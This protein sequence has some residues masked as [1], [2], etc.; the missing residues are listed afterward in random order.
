MVTINLVDVACSVD[1]LEQFWEL[2]NERLELCHKA[3]QCRHKRL[4]GTVSDVSP[5]HFQYGAIARLEKGEVIDDLLFNNYSTLSLGYAGLWECVYK[6]IGKKLTEEDGKQLGK[7]IMQYM[8]DKCA[9][10]REAENIGYSLYGSPIE[11]TAY[12]FAT[13]LQKRFGVIEGV[14]DR[15][16]ITNSYHIHVTE[17][18][19]IFNKLRIEAEFQPLSPGGQISY[20]EIPN[21]TGNTE[22]IEEVIKF[23]Y[24]NI[25]YAELNTKSDYCQECGW[26]GEIEIVED[27]TGKLIWKCP[28]CGNTNQDKMN[29]CRRTCGYLGS[30]F[31]N[32]GR[33]QEI[34][35]R[36][37]HL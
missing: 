32:Q 26:D 36:V 28:N 6:L 23:M 13:C 25:M 12:R 22:A 8:N 17:P 15:N 35:E 31:W 3:L 7:E 21:L 9:A 33:T 20:G 2:F 11:S 29:V 27:E 30:N 1:S 5:L 14:T 19:D 34:K 4:R 18:I 24:D 10:W 16:Y 37:V